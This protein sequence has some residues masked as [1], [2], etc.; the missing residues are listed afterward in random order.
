ME[1]PPIFNTF[2]HLDKLLTDFVQ[3]KRSAAD[4]VSPN[5]EDDDFIRCG[6]VGFAR[7]LPMER[8]EYSHFEYVKSHRDEVVDGRFSTD[9]IR[10][11]CLAA[12]YF[13]GMAEA[14]FM[15]ELDLRLSEAHT[16][17]FMW[18]HSNELGLG[19]K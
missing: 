5:V 1:T 9:W 11:T 4:L 16:P 17:G 10:F 19:T 6:M 2:S 7:H 12:G 14:G 3:C 13:A 8:W 18:M 15:S